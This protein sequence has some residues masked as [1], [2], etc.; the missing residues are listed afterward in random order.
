[1]PSAPP[2]GPEDAGPL[3]LTAARLSIEFRFPGFSED[4]VRNLGSRFAGFLGSG[5]ARAVCTVRDAAVDAPTPLPVEIDDA[6][7]RYLSTVFTRFPASADVGEDV[8]RAADWL[9]VLG[10]DRALRAALGRLGTGDWAKTLVAPL[11]GASVIF[12][13]AAGHG[14]IFL[15]AALPAEAKSAVFR[16]TVFLVLSCLLPHHGGIVLHGAGAVRSGRGYVFLGLSGEGKSTLVRL[17][18]PDSALSDDGVCIRRR[19]DDLH[20]FG[21]PFFQFEA[22]EEDR[23]RIATASAPLGGLYFLRKGGPHR[24]ER[25]NGPE[26]LGEILHNLIHFFRWFPDGTCRLAFEI[27]SRLV[28]TAGA[29]F[30]HFSRDGGFWNVIIP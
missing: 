17:T 10:G 15:N 27:A 19:G 26:A 3:V 13:P 20:V 21:I 6:L 16:E 22:S 25:R 8:E 23:R 5:P 4:F 28:Q 24:V 18:G 11:P 7:R 29:R 12:R 2:P 30:L 1:M 9:R 14:E